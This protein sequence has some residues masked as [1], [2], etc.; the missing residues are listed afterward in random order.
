MKK[1]SDDKSIYTSQ[2]NSFLS[3]FDQLILTQLYQPIIGYQAMALYFSLYT[4][5]RI[6]KPSF[7]KRLINIMNIDLK[8]LVACFDL[9]EGIGLIKTFYYQSEFEHFHFKLYKPL[10]P[11]NFY[12]NHLLANKLKAILG[13]SD[14]EKTKSLFTI[15]EKDLNLYQDISK[16]YQDVYLM[17]E[18]IEDFTSE[19]YLEEVS[20]NIKLNFDDDLL[21]QM[22]KP[23]NLQMILLDENKKENIQ[24]LMLEYDVDEALI[25][26]ALIASLNEDQNNFKDVA[27][28]INAYKQTCLKK[29]ELVNVYQ[30]DLN[31]TS[32]YDRRSV[33]EYLK[34]YHPNFDVNFTDLE[35][36]EQVMRDYQLNNGVMNVLLSYVVNEKKVINNSYLKTIAQSWHN[37]QINTSEQALLKIEDI[38]KASTKKPKSN[39]K[40]YKKTIGDTSSWYQNTSEEINQKDLDALKERLKNR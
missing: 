17:N 29:P 40:S 19:D 34:K 39:F 31:K 11:K 30:K 16:K 15:E 3:S 26:Q 5:S 35:N 20:A 14:F 38:K 7:F 6:S 32:I 33:Y 28:Y 21:K 24:M 13:E 36:I 1:L 22:L 12:N 2:I 23:Y 25:A 10:T 4:E 18:I 9:L 37:A 27:N 8:T